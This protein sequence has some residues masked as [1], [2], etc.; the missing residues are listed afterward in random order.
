MSAFELVRVVVFLF[1]GMVSSMAGS[2]GGGLFLALLSSPLYEYVFIVF[3][4]RRCWWTR[5]VGLLTFFPFT[6]PATRPKSSQ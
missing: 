1:T 2:P 6:L 5:F 4:A 3:R